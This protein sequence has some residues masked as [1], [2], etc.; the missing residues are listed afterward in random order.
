MVTPVGTAAQMDLTLNITMSV[1]FNDGLKICRLLCLWK[2]LTKMGVP[3]HQLGVKCKRCTCF[4]G[5]PCMSKTHITPGAK[6]RSD[7]SLMILSTG[8]HAFLRTFVLQQMP[9]ELL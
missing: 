4:L 9:I 2:G 5:S 3:G 7:H 8:K 6:R 1:E